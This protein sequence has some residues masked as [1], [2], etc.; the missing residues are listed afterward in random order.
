MKISMIGLGKV[1]SATVFNLLNN[2]KID[3]ISLIDVI[4]DKLEGEYL[5]LLHA[6]NGLNSSIKL[7]YSQNIEDVKGS[8]LITITAGFPRKTESSRLDMAISNAKIV[9]EIIEKIKKVEK[10]CLIIMVTNPVDINTYIALKVSE[11]KREH[12][13]GMGSTLD[14]FRFKTVEP[15]ARMILGEH[16]D[17][18]VFVPYDVSE[19][20]K[21]YTIKISKKIIELK[22]GT[23]WAPAIAISSL[24]DSIMN[25]KKDIKVV[26]TLL[27]GE[28]GIKNVCLGIPV[29]LGFNGIEEIIEYKLDSKELEMLNKSANMLKDVI[30]DC[31]KI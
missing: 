22:G 4:P 11:F 21:D 15:K 9:K 23:W 26:S 1:G 5:D 19:K 7:N 6:A 27:N 14:F 10:D 28:Y 3:E 12:V 13:F 25:D 18:A 29:K 30:K 2:K 31:E 24:I 8:H 17:S 20:S 16:G